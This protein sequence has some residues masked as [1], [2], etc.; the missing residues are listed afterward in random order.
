[1]KLSVIVP[2]FNV[3]KYL[4]KCLDSL[5]CQTFQDY[6][7]LLI[8]DGSL[9]S[10]KIIAQ[11]YARNNIKFKYLE[12]VN[13]GLSDARN[14]GIKHATGE[15]LAFID[16]DDYVDSEMFSKMFEKQQ[17]SN[18]DIV[19]CDMYYEYED[20]TLKY[21]SAG[22]FDTVT[23][24]LNLGVISVNNSACNKIFRRELFTDLEF[25]K[26]KWYE[27][28]F[29]V[30]I[31]LYKAN[32][33]SRVPNAL[34]FYLQRDGSIVHE[35]NLKMFNVYEA[36]LNVENSLKNIVFDQIELSEII[37]EMFI[38]HGLFLTT[39]R[40]K[41]NGTFKNRV[42]FFSLNMDYLKVHYPKWYKNKS[43]NDYPLKSK[44]IFVLLRFKMYYLVAL[45]LKRE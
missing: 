26:G 12:K 42:N 23:S 25:P 28:L 9:D 24:E 43:I 16:S 3:E 35:N 37:N 17:V 5:A 31:L 15:F 44:I 45:L 38:R 1:M 14:F 11:N 30:P 41:N 27:D 10:S 29:I 21:T 32:S 40:I 2:I 36:I 39:L 22:E 34:Y 33:V 7:V 18:S 13:G 6:E 8:N 19:V 4:E 20:G